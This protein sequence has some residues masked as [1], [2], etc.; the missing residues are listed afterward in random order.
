M[1]SLTSYK[2][3]IGDRLTRRLI[4]A[5]EKGEVKDDEIPAISDYILENIDKAH[6]ATQLL[7]FLDNLAAKWP[8]FSTLAVIEEGEKKV[9][10]DEQKAQEVK[11]LLDEKKFDEALDVVKQANAGGGS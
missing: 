1:D 7:Q 3:R 10:D 6:D 8:I 2:N 11:G 9:E 5:A 4:Q